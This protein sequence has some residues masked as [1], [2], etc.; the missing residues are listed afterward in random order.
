MQSFG[1]RGI[2]SCGPKAGTLERPKEKP[3]TL[4]PKALKPLT[5]TP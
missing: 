5:L 2:L 1:W 4:S 3:E